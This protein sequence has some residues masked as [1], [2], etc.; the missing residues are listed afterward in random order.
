MILWVAWSKPLGI[1]ADIVGSR[2]LEDRPA[3][4]RAILQ[5]FE[6]AQDS[7]PVEEEA[8]ATVGDEFQV[9]TATWQDALRMTLRVQ[10]ALPDDLRLRFGIGEGQINTIGDSPAGPI[11][12]GTAWLNARAAIETVE[13]Q[14]HD[15]EV[16][17][18]FRSE[19]ASLTA[20]VTAQLLMRDHIVARMKA[21]ER[22]LFAALLSGA[23]QRAAARRKD[24]Q[25]AVSQAVHRSGAIALLTADDVLQSQSDQAKEATSCS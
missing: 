1:I 7:V 25:A 21:R 3:A 13:Q 23:T 2:D 14:Q 19:D 17:T 10:V 15:D 5:A 22:R 16:L 20:A 18:G 24:F 9:I 6:H 8:W 4:Q 12:D 11:Q